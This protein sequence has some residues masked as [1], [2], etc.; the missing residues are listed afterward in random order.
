MLLSAARPIPPRTALRA[1]QV[2]AVERVLLAGALLTLA[3]D[4]GVLVALT[5]VIA[6]VTAILQPRMRA[7]YEFGAQLGP[8]EPPTA[9]LPDGRLPVQT[10][11]T[12]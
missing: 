8:G 5:L 1:H 10:G 11:R 2:L 12:G 6:L 4:S 7:R 9:G 3:R